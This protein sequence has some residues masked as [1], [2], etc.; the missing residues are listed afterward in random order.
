MYIISFY[1]LLQIGWNSSSVQIQSSGPEQS[2]YLRGD[3]GRY[4]TSCS[5]CQ[6]AVGKITHTATLESTYQE[7]STRLYM[8]RMPN[9]N[10]VFRNGEGKYM[11]YCHGC[12]AGGTTPEFVAFHESDPNQPWAQFEL[13][14]QSNGKA[15]LRNI[16]N[17]K[18]LTRCNGCSP[19]SKLLDVVTLHT[20]DKD[21]TYAQWEII[22][23]Q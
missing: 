4:I 9:G 1:L 23:Q 11:S 19:S 13:T 12:I 22:P 16:H 2:V 8:S 10:Y 14:W 21:G 6:S 5:N 7:Y 18:Y 17:G 3:L 15:N 20:M